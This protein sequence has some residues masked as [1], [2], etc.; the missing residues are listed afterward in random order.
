MTY[1][2]G[3]NSHGQVR[4]LIYNVVK[5]KI[6]KS[7]NSVPFTFYFDYIK[8]ISKRRQQKRIKIKT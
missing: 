4:K 6:K 8:M 3:L 2:Y 5:S 7:T 1:L